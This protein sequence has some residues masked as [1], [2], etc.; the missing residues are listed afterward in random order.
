MAS[1][2]NLTLIFFIRIHAFL[3]Y[4]V[5]RVTYGYFNFLCF[6]NSYNEY[7]LLKF[8]LKFYKVVAVGYIH[9]MCV[10]VWIDLLKT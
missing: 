8:H 5:I 10:C 2:E 4:Y 3:F 9:L 7:I 1:V 6:L